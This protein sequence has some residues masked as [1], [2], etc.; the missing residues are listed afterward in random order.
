MAKIATVY[1]QLHAKL[2]LRRWSPS[3]IADFVIQADDQLAEVIEQIPLH[4]QNNDLPSNQE[5]KEMEQILP[6][7][8][9]QRTSLVMVLLYYRLAINRV[10]QTYWLE[11]STN[12]ARARSVC[13][14]SAMGLVQSAT[15][16]HVAFRR[17]RSW[18]FAMVTFSA[19]VTL[20]LE[21][22]RTAEPDLRLVQAI[23]DSERTLESV[24]SE[25][26]LARDAL[27]IL[28]E[29]RTA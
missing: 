7:I 8:A 3:G 2:R 4:L 12:F 25:N 23:A 16:G 18:D 14:S 5:H 15:S 26:K 11:G 28:R 9:T 29:L 1:H 20:A 17:L 24:Q 6:W 27:L 13:I 19:T 21:V 10:L 22:R